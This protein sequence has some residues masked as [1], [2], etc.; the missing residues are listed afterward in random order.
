[1]VF[2]RKIKSP[3]LGNPI[4]IYSVPNAVPSISDGLVYHILDKIKKLN[5]DRIL[6]EDNELSLAIMKI[7]DQIPNNYLVTYNFN[8]SGNAK[9]ILYDPVKKNY[10]VHRMPFDYR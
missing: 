3:F 8:K 5:V 10:V 4:T 1:M 6:N 2:M 7:D 9:Q